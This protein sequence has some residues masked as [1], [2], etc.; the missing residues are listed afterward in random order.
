M[1]DVGSEL[2]DADRD[3]CLDGASDKEGVELGDADRD[4]WLD[5]TKDDVGSELGIADTDG[6]S[7]GIGGTVDD[8]VVQDSVS[9]TQTLDVASS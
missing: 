2:G 9:T 6:G 8:D 4:G 7:V 5:G 1:D 3:G